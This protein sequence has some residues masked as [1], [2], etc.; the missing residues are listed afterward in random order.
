[1]PQLIPM[2]R[3]I[4]GG[5]KSISQEKASIIHTVDFMI[6]PSFVALVLKLILAAYKNFSPFLL[7]SLKQAD[8]CVFVNLKPSSLPTIIIF[9][10]FSGL[11][12][13]NSYSM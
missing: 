7:F 6:F 13:I 11:L 10:F 3:N 5:Q 9:F 8:F 12:P 2:S 4:P 1:M